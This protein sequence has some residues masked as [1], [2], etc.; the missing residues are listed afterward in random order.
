[1][2]AW[3]LAIACTA[4][5][6][7]AQAARLADGTAI[8]V[9]LT[10][11]L[12]STHEEVGSRV[13]MEVAQPVSAEGVVVIPAGATVWGAVQ[14]VKAGKT[15]HIDIE[16]LRLP[17]KGIVKL[18]CL[19]Q[20]TNRVAKDEIKVELQVGGDLGA[21]MGTEFTAYLD[22]DVNLEVPAAPGAP[23]PAAAEVA[24][25]AAPSAPSAPEAVPAAPAAAEVSP[26]AVPG[27]A[28]P[29]GEVVSQPAPVAAPPAKEETPSAPSAPAV[30]A[31]VAP[32]APAAAVEHPAPLPQPG[33]YITVE[34]FSEPDG[35]DI[36]IDDEF[37][38]STPSILKLA[39]GK[40][41]IEYRLVSY[42]PHS[43]PLDLTPGTGL[44]TV[45]WAF[46]KQP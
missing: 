36:L 31:P 46:E 40:H 27:P 29:A 26:A 11:D 33:E 14:V 5:V 38:G 18:R 6:V 37:H 44:R 22:Q 9:R 15:L 30:S 2:L 43:K 7:P 4:S 32:P 3:G 12:L 19:P 41:Q 39:P 17:N 24:P 8:R 35:A 10:M 1:M 13:D 42:K 20:R 25:A 23:A 28:A 34:C 45:R 16:G 21:P